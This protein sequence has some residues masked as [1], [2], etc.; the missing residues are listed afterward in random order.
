VTQS[1][2]KEQAYGPK[3]GI[4]T[5]K[6]E[7]INM[8]TLLLKAAAAGLPLSLLL[9]GAAGAAPSEDR[10]LVS[11]SAALTYTHH[12]S[13]D[14]ADGPGHILMVGEATGTNVNTGPS[15]YMADGQVTNVDMGDLMQ[16]N[17]THQGYFTVS[18]KAGSTTTQWHGKVST[19]VG[20]DKTPRTTFAG[21]WTLVSGSGKYQGIH[22]DGTYRGHFSSPTEYTVEWKGESTK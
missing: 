19:T 20:P 5:Q 15:D 10:V 12:Q 3:Q 16:G 17:G 11:G 7:G 18:S 8:R 21:T 13:V 6:M 2:V 22:G 1:V 4:A 9:L 14:V